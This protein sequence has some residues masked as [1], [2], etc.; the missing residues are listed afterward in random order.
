MLVHFDA[1]VI[2]LLENIYSCLVSAV[3]DDKKLLPLL[4]L[5][6]Q[7]TGIFTSCWQLAYLDFDAVPGWSFDQLLQTNQTLIR[8]K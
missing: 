3:E 5:F 8:K 1:Y 4:H 2:H 6:Q 7:R